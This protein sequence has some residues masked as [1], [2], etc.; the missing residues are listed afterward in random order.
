MTIEIYLGRLLIG[1]L[2]IALFLFIATIALS[3]YDYFARK[4]KFIVV[5]KQAGK[6]AGFLAVAYAVGYAVLEITKGG[7]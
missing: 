7:P 6:L 5:A 1:V 3:I 4:P 2:V